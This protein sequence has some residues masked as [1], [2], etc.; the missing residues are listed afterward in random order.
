LN[1][2]DNLNSDLENTWYCAVLCAVSQCEGKVVEKLA[3]SKAKK[4]SLLHRL[5][6]NESGTVAP[7]FGFSL[8]ALSAVVGGAVDYGRWVSA[9]RQNQMAADGALLAASRAAQLALRD[10]LADTVVLENAVKAATAHYDAAKSTQLVDDVKKVSFKKGATLNDWKIEGG[11]KL[12][13]PFL[14]LIGI[15]E[16]GVVPK[17]S[18]SV[19]LGGSGSSSLEISL[20]LDITGSMCADNVGP[21]TAGTKMTALKTAAKSLVNTVV[22]DNQ[23]PGGTSSR[24][25]LVPFS[26]RIRVGADGSAEGAAMMKKITN[27][28]DKWSGYYND[29][30]QSTG[31]GGSEGSGNWNCTQYTA[32]YKTNWKIMPCVVDR[33]RDTQWGSWTSNGSNSGEWDL[34]DD[35]PG[36]NYWLNAHGGDRMPVSRDS[37][38]VTPTNYAQYYTNLKA[39]SGTFSDPAAHWNYNEYGDCADVQNSNV[40]MPLTNNRAALAARI[41]ALSAYGSTGGAMGTQW[42]WYMLS[43]K[44]KNIWPSTSEP[45]AYSETVSVAGAEP[46]L[47]KVAV[48]MTDGAYNTVR[49]WK[50]QDQ[51]KMS[52]YAKKVCEQMKASGVIVYT[53]GFGLDQLPAAEKAR[54]IDTLTQCST[55]K[56]ITDANNITTTVYKFYNAETAQALQ[57]AFTDIALS[58]SKLRITE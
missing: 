57:G 49:G 26:T 11:A 36:S 7:I 28:N 41:D 55:S 3:V 39:Q 43:P 27:L 4:T 5:M 30:T 29:C 15:S 31:G 51:I 16:L 35:A 58:L 56:Q 9:S 17:G 52:N 22:W 32:R 25:A 8:L 12:K 46:K 24:V 21:C 53:V 37:R 47:K 33:F 48:L 40:I 13:T 14:Q 20:M 38:D 19:A 42:A 54:A 34:T 10:G 50:D 45:A 6:L 44:W 18:S 23:V 1:P 2:S